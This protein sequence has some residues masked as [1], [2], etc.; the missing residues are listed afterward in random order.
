MDLEKIIKVVSTF[1]AGKRLGVIIYIFFNSSAPASCMHCQSYLSADASGI[2]IIHQRILHMIVYLY[3]Y[4]GLKM[5]C[6]YCGVG[7]EYYANPQHSSRKSCMESTTGYHYFVASILS[8]LYGVSQLS[9]EAKRCRL[10]NANTLRD[11][12]P[13]CEADRP[14]EGDR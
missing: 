3:I 9:E 5:R 2:K 10:S 11:R 4:L 12:V 14:S 13:N 6:K 8:C 1:F 7:L